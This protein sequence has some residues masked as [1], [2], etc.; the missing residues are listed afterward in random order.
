[1]T[2]PAATPIIV[3]LDHVQLA[4]PAGKEAA[5]EHFYCAVL[6]FERVAKP[7]ELEQRG[8]CWFRSGAVNLHLGVDPAFTPARKAHPAFVVTSLRVVQACLEAAGIPNVW[9]TQLAGFERFYAS[10][11]FGNRLEFV[12]PVR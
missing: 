7:T 10:D 6:G 9:D 5:A 12:E 1:M 11:P 8:S 2:K 4:M 3:R